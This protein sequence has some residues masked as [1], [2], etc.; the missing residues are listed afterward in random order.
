M[1]SF[2]ILLFLIFTSSFSQLVISQVTITN[3]NHSLEISGVISGYYNYRVLKPE[4]INQ[5]K[6]NNRFRLR[7]AQIQFEG[8]IG[9]TWAYELQ[10]DIADLASGQSS[11]DG[12]NPGLMDAYVK[13]KGLKFFDI[14]VGFGKTPYSRSSLV[15]FIYSPYWQRA[16][17][18]RGDIFTRRDIGITLSQSYWRQR[19][20]VYAGIYN[21]LG[22]ISLR[23]ENDA[24]GS[25]EYISRVDFAYPSRFRYREIDDRHVPIPMF[26]IGLNGR[27]TRRNL[28]EGG[29]FPPFSGGEY[30]LRVI[31]GERYVYGFDAA[32]MYRGFSGTF[33]IHQYR[34]Q[35]RLESHP[36]LQ[37][38]PVEQTHKYFLAGGWVAQLNYF[39]KS[40]KTILSVRY[41]QL[42]L[43]DL[44]N[45]N[46]ER[47]SCAIAYQ[48][49]GFNS[50]IKFQY[51]NIIKEEVNIDPLRWT[52]Q[53]RIGWQ[54]LLK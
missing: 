24:T 6:N 28:P 48:I 10:V 8:R 36:L 29:T 7:D 40:W 52:E 41:E 54:F 49:N 26:Q 51:F 44:V 45:G 1:K 46:S 47:L 15:P 34:G 32:F 21:G 3:G 53:F 19:I 11:I 50:M 27:Y 30:G 20:N 38:L 39:W 35:P 22:E 16:Q 2:A 5:N 9:R 33:E 13:Y 25:V 12:E 17:I 4:A 42:D 43:N 18:V 37:G 14:Q 31:D 23:G